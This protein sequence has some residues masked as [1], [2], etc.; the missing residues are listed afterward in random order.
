MTA[1]RS[2]T[3]MDEAKSQSTATTAL[4][5]HVSALLAR[6]HC[7]VPSSAQVHAEKRVSDTVLELR[8]CY[9]VVIFRI[10]HKENRKP[11]DP[12]IGSALSSPIRRL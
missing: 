5:L 10:S 2:S 3:I 6:N 11:V 4:R 12:L 1:S 7:H 8:H 9:G